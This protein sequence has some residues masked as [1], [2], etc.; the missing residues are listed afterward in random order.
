MGVLTRRRRSPGTQL[1][2]PTSRPGPIT[3]GVP[4]PPAG[5]T[6]AWTAGLRVDLPDYVGEQIRE[7]CHGM[8]CTQVALVLRLLADFRDARARPVFQILQ[9]DLVADRRKRR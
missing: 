8:R 9:E 7:A 1:S 5:A 4:I 3:P 2:P 6:V